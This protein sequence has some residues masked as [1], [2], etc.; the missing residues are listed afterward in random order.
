MPDG[1]E[2]LATEGTA[3]ILED[4]GLTCTPVSKGAP[5][6][7]PS[8]LD[9]ID[10]GQIDLVINIPREYDE[11]GRPDGFQIRRRAV[12]RGV[13]LITDLQLARALVEALRWKTFDDLDVVPL[14]EYLNRESRTLG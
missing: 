11:M 7:H 8:A 5:T 2:L 4:L 13:P 10:D 6:E 3:E 9:L 14:D 1:F 12:D